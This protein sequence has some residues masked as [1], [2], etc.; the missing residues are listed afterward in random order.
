MATRPFLSIIVPVYNGG[1][2]F[3]QCLAAIQRSRVLAWEFIVVDDGSTDRSAAIAKTFGATVLKTG[4]R[5]GPGS[6]RNL[7]AHH[8]Q[9]DYLCFLDADCEVCPDALSLLVQT[10]KQHPTID[11]VFGSYDDAPAAANFVAQY[12]NLLHHYVHQTGCEEATTFWAGCGAIKRS[13]FL[14]VGGFNVQ[15]YKRPSIEDIDLGYRIRQGGGTI[16]LAKHVQVKHH[17][18]WSLKSLVKTDVFDRGIPWTRLLLQNKAN[19]VNDLNLQVSNRISVVLTYSLLT[20]AI[21]SLYQFELTFLAVFSAIWLLILNANVYRFFREK[22]GILFALKSIALHWLY[23]LYSGIALL[24]GTL[25]H[26]QYVAG[27]K[28]ILVRS[29]KRTIKFYLLAGEL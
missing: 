15:R 20:L 26:W 5:L 13:T 1:D 8:A 4:G 2:P 14:A 3:V 22:R 6:A 28:F 9:G 21:A 18:A 11:A 17:K 12:K 10:L 16:Y 27:Q 23:Y 7:G 25:L 19:F 29:L 24:L